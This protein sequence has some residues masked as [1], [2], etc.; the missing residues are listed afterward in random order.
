MLIL[1]I[2]PAGC[3]GPGGRASR[4][5]AGSL[6]QEF[7]LRHASP[8]RMADILSA[9]DLGR[10]AV[11]GE[12]NGI[13]VIGG[14]DEL[15]KTGAIVEIADV[16]EPYVLATLA[17]VADARTIPSNVEIAR[18]LGDVAIGT[19]AVPPPAGRTRG[20]IVDIHRDHI[21]AIMPE[22]IQE[23]LRTVIRASS[24]ASGSPRAKPS[25][26]EPQVGRAGGD[27]PTPEG[28]PASF[29][30]DAKSAPTGT[31]EAPSRPR[32]R[33]VQ[34]ISPAAPA[35]SRTMRTASPAIDE[36]TSVPGGP[37][38]E[39]EQGQMS[40]SRAPALITPNRFE[41]VSLANAD[42]VLKV[43]LPEQLE[44]T[45]LLD[46]AGE[47]LH[48]DYLYEP[49]KIKGTVT[50]RLHGK[51][52]GQ[53]RVRDLYSL[54]ESVLKF[55]GY[56]MICHKDNLVTIAPVADA[57]LANP[58]LLDS[59]GQIRTGDMVVTSF[60]EL[61]HIAA[62][63]ASTLLQNMKLS[64]AVTPVEGSPSLIVTCYAHQI[65]RIERLL[66]V[67]DRPGPP[68]EFKFR[69]LR[70]T[71]AESLTRKLQALMRQMGNVAVAGGL[72]HATG[73]LSLPPDGANDGAVYLDADERTNRIL[74]IGTA[75]QIALADRLIDSLDIAQKDLRVLKIYDLQHV[76]AQEIKTKLQELEIIGA[77]SGMRTPAAAKI[78]G[79]Q[80]SEA[81]V[82]DDA[83]VVILDASNSLAINATEEQH[84]R[85]EAMLTYLD[86]EVRMESIP[87]EIYF[88]ENQDPAALA[89]V[90]E[91][92]IH[93]TV[94]DKDGKLQKIL[95][96]ANDQVLIVPDK[97]TFSLI[98]YAARRNQE[99]ISKLIKTLDRR[100]PQ[101]LI[102]VTLVEIR[103]MDEFN[104]DL[105]LI[106]SFP[107]LTETGG[108]TGQFLVDQNTTVVDKLL[109]SSRSQYVDFEISSGVGTGFYA[110]RHIN[111]LLT[112]V[113][114]KNY[115]RVLAKPK[116]L[117]N[118]NEKG[119]IKTADTTYVTTK[120]S[121]PVTSGTAGQQNTLIETAVKYEPYD[122]GITLEIT[123]HI[124]EGQLLR[125]EIMLSRSDFTSVAGDKP[126]D[127]TSSDIATIVTVPDTSTIILG[128]MLKLNQS[129]ATAKVP[130]FGDLPLVGSLFRR[131]DNSDIQSKLYIFVRA[132]IIRPADVATDGYR[133]L[134]RISDQNRRAFEKHEQEF[135][136]YQSWPGVKSKPVD[137]PKVLE[138][139]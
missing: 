137:P 40:D 22:R 88:L 7:T 105:N 117:V 64:L 65:D 98:V 124:S 13:K 86:A 81:V 100:R 24:D 122:A 30:A 102:D 2:L 63:A 96:D 48:L 109:Q 93:E 123:P 27:H 66:A 34:A 114:T 125:L 3:G 4:Q 110:D 35:P 126:P 9:L 39:S 120:S 8:E 95:R 89:E 5:V 73:Q 37:T 61:R 103:K 74:L 115:G 46:L 62:S 17:P 28:P 119:S 57:L 129:K 20:A 21:V 70:Y 113:Q 82:A 59:R 12:G 42:E 136:G 90:I 138:A 97:N 29:A 25:E 15:H 23:R 128:G 54:L 108:Q 47:Y 121:I 104:Y 78:E 79:G 106:T 69:Q 112:A 43:D 58:D 6:R 132:E 16:N 75:E 131:I 10:V 91:K 101:V 94:Q 52:Q 11:V 50:L 45:Q 56:A 67:V 31:T 87:Y 38:A 134:K 60:F 133:D 99:W 84:A 111:A 135:Q 68:R 14:P 118:D 36:D 83:V 53:M 32:V 139:R 116:V 127:Q 72:P 107:D 18:F 130:I 41:A 71:M 44:M 85:I 92:I 49:E 55:K 1:T 19:F 26:T 80:I 51:T 77:R 33:V 76:E